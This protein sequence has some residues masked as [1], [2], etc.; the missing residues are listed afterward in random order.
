MYN[1]NVLVFCPKSHSCQMLAMKSALHSHNLALQL[2]GR[3][4]RQ[5]PLLKYRV[6]RVCVHFRNGCINTKDTWVTVTSLRG[7]CTE[8]DLSVHNHFVWPQNNHRNKKVKR[9]KRRKQK[10]AEIA[11]AQFVNFHPN[12]AYDPDCD[13]LANPYP[14]LTWAWP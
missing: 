9:I 12:P 6:F 5:S 13:A 4:V 10:C 1:W 2:A 8:I 14:S 11:H 3:S 7:Y